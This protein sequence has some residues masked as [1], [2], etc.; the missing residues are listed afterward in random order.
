MLLYII[1]LKLP[2]N[3]LSLRCWLC[4]WLLCIGY[5]NLIL[6]SPHANYF[7]PLTDYDKILHIKELIF[8]TSSQEFIISSSET[9]K[10]PYIWNCGF[11]CIHKTVRA[12]FFWNNGNFLRTNTSLSIL[13]RTII[14]TKIIISFAKII[15]SLGSI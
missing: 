1:V 8:V 6:H 15:T 13:L 5:K 2:Q 10:V 4:N 7:E 11:S 12:E 9:D 3:I 14:L